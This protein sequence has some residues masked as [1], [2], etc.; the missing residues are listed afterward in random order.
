MRRHLIE[1]GCEA[2]NLVGAERAGTDNLGDGRPAD[3]DRAGLVEE[4]DLA[5]RQ[6]FECRAAFHDDTAARRARQTRH[7]GDGHREDQRARC[8]DHQN[9]NG[10]N[11][12]AG[13]R[14]GCAR[15]RQA[16]QQENAGISVGQANERRAR[17]LGVRH[18]PD[19]AGVGAL[20]CRSR[21][22]QVEGPAGIHDTAADGI[23]R[24]VLD[25]ERLARERAFVEHGDLALDQSVDRNDLARLHQQEVAREH[26]VDRR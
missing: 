16:H 8:G 18:E 22:P 17:S 11:Q 14:P 25:G 13:D 20:V 5:A 3:G 10:A 7:D 6:L 1:R 24:G 15:D 19:D 2:Q 9:C 26:L 21:G 12:V 4:Q 23:A